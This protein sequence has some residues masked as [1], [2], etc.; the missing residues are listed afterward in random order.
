MEIKDI[1]NYL[2][3]L[4]NDNKTL[5]L[6]RIINMLNFLDL[7]YTI[8]KSVNGYNIIEVY[9]LYFLVETEKRYKLV[10]I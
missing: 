3:F 2:K 10:K 7:E 6:K 1:K 9:E 5:Q 8:L 4:E